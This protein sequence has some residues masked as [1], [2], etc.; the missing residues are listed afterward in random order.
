MT[1]NTNSKQRCEY[2]PIYWQV[3]VIGISN[4]E[5]I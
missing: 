1:E 2:D 5:F 4:L 3:S